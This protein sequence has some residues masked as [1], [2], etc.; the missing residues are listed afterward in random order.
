MSG[1][2]DILWNSGCSIGLEETKSN[3][4]SIIKLNMHGQIMQCNDSGFRLIIH[5]NGVVEK[6]Y[7]LNNE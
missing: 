3:L 7:L 6:K 2:E 4:N 5:D 1:S